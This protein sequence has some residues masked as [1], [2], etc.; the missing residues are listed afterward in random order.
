MVKSPIFR[1]PQPISFRTHPHLGH[2]FG[3]LPG[4]PKQLFEVA[5]VS[6]EGGLQRLG[7]EPA[8]AGSGNRPK[9]RPKMEVFPKIDGLFHGKSRAPVFQETSTC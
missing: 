4:A 9:T 5:Q 2:A 7:R 1:V 8:A 6:K 3:A